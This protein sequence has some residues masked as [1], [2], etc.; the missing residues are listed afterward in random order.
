MGRQ[1]ENEIWKRFI[2]PLEV[3]GWGVIAVMTLLV[4][5][6][7][8]TR[9]EYLQVALVGAFTAVFMLVLFQWLAPRFGFPLWLLYLSV[10]GGI[11]LV[12]VTCYVLQ[13][14]DVDIDLIY[15]IIVTAAGIMVGWPL[16]L[17]AA[18]LAFAAEL[19]VFALRTGLSPLMLLTEGLHLTVFLAAGY[20]ATTLAGTIRQ[21]AEGATKRSDELSLL[22]DTSL[23]VAASLDLDTTLPRLVEKIA[24]G[25]PATSCRICL[26]DP[27]HQYLVTR[28]AY[29]LRPEA[30]WEAALGQQYPLD[31]LPLHRRAIETGRPVIARQD[32]PTLVM[33]QSERDMLF[34]MGMKAACLVPLVAEGQP[35][36]V[37]SAAQPL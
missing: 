36:G 1:D 26:L 16:A 5:V 18:L 3:S 32:D 17:L 27:K 21:Q 15:V 20:L 19:V 37:I 30:D 10:C 12:A 34:I 8:L 11:A 24:K 28:G 33:S 22:L 4:L 35:V 7:P 29:V 23:T 25:L 31:D 6:L 9:I 14:Y 2:R 13:P